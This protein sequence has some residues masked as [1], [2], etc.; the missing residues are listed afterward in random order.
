MCVCVEYI[1][2]MLILLVSQWLQAVS[3]RLHRLGARD[4]HF[5]TFSAPLAS[6]AS[7]HHS[8]VPKMA[9]GHRES[10]WKSPTCWTGAWDWTWLW[11]ITVM[12]AHLYLYVYIYIRMYIYIYTYVYIYIYMCNY[13]YDCD[14]SDCHDLINADLQRSCRASGCFPCFLCPGLGVCRHMHLSHVT[15]GSFIGLDVDPVWMWMFVGVHTFK[16][17]LH[18]HLLHCVF[19]PC[20]GR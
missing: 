4:P 16:C 17:G 19:L 11:Y 5:P 13:Y 1:H 6:S 8:T 12:L 18:M 9:R 14:H 15:P 7:W 10:L 3:W 2:V 20:H